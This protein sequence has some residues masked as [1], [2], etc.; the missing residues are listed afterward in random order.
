M[1]LPKHFFQL[2]DRNDAD[3]WLRGAFRWGKARGTAKDAVPLV[4][5]ALATRL[6]L[7]V[8]TCKYFLNRIDDAL[9]I[10]VSLFLS[11]IENSLRCHFSNLKSHPTGG[12]HNAG[13]V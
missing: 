9:T 7:P 11:S 1:L 5:D 4:A 10:N 6:T 12:I 8:P 13:R 2:V 3:I